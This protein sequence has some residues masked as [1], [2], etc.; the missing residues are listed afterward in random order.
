[1]FVEQQR[2]LCMY[3]ATRLSNRTRP[4]PLRARAFLDPCF[5]VAL[6]GLLVLQAC[7]GESSGAEE[8]TTDGAASS[9]AS[10]TDGGGSND[11]GGSGNDTDGADSNGTDAGDDSSGTDG[12]DDSGDTDDTD[13]P[14]A[15]DGSR[16]QLQWFRPDSGPEQLIGIFD[17]ELGIACSFRTAADG[18]LRCLPTTDVSRVHLDAATGESVPVQPISEACAPA[19]LVDEA[20]GSSLDCEPPM[21]NVFAPG[22]LRDEICVGIS[23]DTCTTTQAPGEDAPPNSGYLFLGDAVEPSVFV[24]GEL[25]V[26]DGDTRLRR[27]WLEAEDGA[28]VFWDVYDTER[29]HVCAFAMAA[30]GQLRCL[31]VL[32][33]SRTGYVESLDEWLPFRSGNTACPPELIS[34]VDDAGPYSC[35]DA[36]HTLYTTGDTVDEVCLNLSDGMCTTIQILGE[37]PPAGAAFFLADEVVDPSVFAAGER[38]MGEGD[39]RLVAREVVTE[40]GFRIETEL[41]DTEYDGACRFA[42]AAD[43]ERRCLPTTT[44]S[45]GHYDTRTMEW[46]RYQGGNTGCM[47]SAIVTQQPSQTFTCE[48]RRSEV[49]GIEGEVERVCIAPTAGGDC[50][51]WLSISDSAPEGAALYLAGDL[52]DPADFVGGSK[53]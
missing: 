15:S 6:V 3:V 9:G 50:A 39:D 38:M 16:L 14:G 31:P 33:E 1:M 47:P 32:P 43:G 53:D 25:V 51:S 5:R 48:P 27:R 12:P 20:V 37:D 36:T 34:A 44:G 13:D 40:D 35:E 30:D 7:G 41:L 4:T 26:A 18:V 21:W 42:I 17:D 46:I 45:G 22:E 24:S 10:A 52:L 2:V 29:D 49:R 19:F 23:G 28:R 11:G 8:A